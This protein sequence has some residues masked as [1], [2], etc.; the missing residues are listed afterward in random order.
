MP[1][2][3]DIIIKGVAASPGIAIGKVFLLENDDI[4]LIRKE[5]PEN[6]RKD[7]KKRLNDAIEKTKA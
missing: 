3:K 1:N 4:C 6:A 7:E 5:I 2:K